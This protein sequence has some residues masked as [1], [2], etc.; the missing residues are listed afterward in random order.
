MS[1]SGLPSPPYLT[2]P[3]DADGS[4]VASP[5]PPPPPPPQP[6]AANARAPAPVAT[7]RSNRILFTCVSSSVTRLNYGGAT[8]TRA[9]RRP[10]RRKYR[11][12]GPSFQPGTLR[13]R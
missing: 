11:E 1:T 10:A 9:R 6:V 8:A 13:L 3:H 5:P 2:A 7:N 4:A 12:I